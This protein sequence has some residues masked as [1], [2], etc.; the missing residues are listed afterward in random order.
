MWEMTQ[1]LK[2]VVL[3]PAL[4]LTR[5]SNPGCFCTL[6]ENESPVSRTV[7]IIGIFSPSHSFFKYLRGVVHKIQDYCN[8]A[9]NY[10]SLVMPFKTDPIFKNKLLLMDFLNKAIKSLKCNLLDQ[11]RN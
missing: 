5:I 7:W 3:F 11:N 10:L 9:K 6:S 1:R 2:N 4:L 8:S